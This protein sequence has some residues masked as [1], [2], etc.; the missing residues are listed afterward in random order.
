MS[1]FSGIKKLARSAIKTF[2]PAVIATIPV[3]GPIAAIAVRGVIAAKAAS[4][5]IGKVRAKPAPAAA[6]VTPGVGM[7]KAAPAIVGGFIPAKKLD[8]GTR[9]GSPGDLAWHA[10][11]LVRR[12]SAQ[13]V[14]FHGRFKTPTKTKFV[15]KAGPP[16][17]V[18]VQQMSIFS[19]IPA[20]GRAVGAAARTP[21]GRAV[22]AGGTTA[23]AIDV[24]FDEFGNPVRRRRRR[25][26]FGNARAAKRAIRRIKG[27]QKMLKDIEKLLPRRSAPRRSRR[28][29]PEG[30]THVR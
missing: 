8:R 1:L 15:Q 29:L 2:A 20:I 7:R 5:A 28:D 4:K 3:V 13:D 25:M 22:I 9:A 12:G 23:A 11:S 21:A 26:N 6:R 30:H 24:I 19:A 14:A 18:G 10:Q 16:G 27:T 17:A